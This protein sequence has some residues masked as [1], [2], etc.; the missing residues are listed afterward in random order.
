MGTVRARSPL[1]VG[2]VATCIGGFLLGWNLSLLFHFK[3]PPR[4]QRL[5]DKPKYPQVPPAP[6][7]GG[8][9]SLLNLNYSPKLAISQEQ[10]DFKPSNLG[11]NQSLVLHTDHAQTGEEK[12]E[13]CRHLLV[14]TGMAGWNV[15]QKEFVDLRCPKRL[16]LL[17]T[18]AARARIKRENDREDVR[19]MQVFS[20]SFDR[21]LFVAYHL[22]LVPF[23]RPSVPAAR[24]EATRASTQTVVFPTSVSRLP[25]LIVMSFLAWNMA[26]SASRAL[27]GVAHVSSASS[28]AA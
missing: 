9:T 13:R 3:Q 18:A 1:G 4:W 25:S 5:S 8:R 22:I 28:F 14:R 26:W 15:D 17:R 23:G 10:H 12:A 11:C 6:I 27:G 24:S 2:F 16:S 19:T 21:H 7:A 20:T